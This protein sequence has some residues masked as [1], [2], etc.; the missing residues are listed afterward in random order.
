VRE[1]DEEDE[2]MLLAL[3]RTRLKALVFALV[4][5]MAAPR[6]ARWLRGF[7]EQRRRAGGG[8]LSYRVPLGAADA[9]DRAAVW[10][11]PRKERRRR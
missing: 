10:A 5:S 11:R 7:G 3:L 8:T 6:I 1:P 2:T 4:L 9:L